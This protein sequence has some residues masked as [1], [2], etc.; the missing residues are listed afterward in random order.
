MLRFLDPANALTLVSL[1]AAF[2]GVVLAIEGHT[3]FAL[4]ALI[5]SGVCDL[6]DGLLARRIPRDEQQK[7]FGGVLDALVD[8]SAFG[9]APAL[10]LYCASPR[11]LAETVVLASLPLSVVWRVAYFEVVGLQ[12]ENRARYYRGLPA[13]YVAL[14]LP[15]TGLLGLADAGWFR[16][17]SLTAI[18][19]L[20]V[21]M[22]SMWRCRKPAGWAYAFFFLL[23]IIAVVVLA[24]NDALLPNGLRN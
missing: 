18:V 7:R 1:L 23:A 24:R 6:F 10:I 8:A 21:A 15:L 16:W 13:T 19:V 3:G 22:L 17:G 11:H 4:I 12:A 14:V 20:N 2:T 9:L 5:V